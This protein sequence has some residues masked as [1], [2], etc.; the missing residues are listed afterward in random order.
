MKRIVLRVLFVFSLGLM[1]VPTLVFA[2]TNE[3]LNQPNIMKW[4]LGI[5]GTGLLGSIGYILKFRNAIKEI[6]EFAIEL[7][8]YISKQAESADLKVVK[9]EGHEAFDSIADIIEKVGMKKQAETL[10]NLL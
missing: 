2:G 10:R 4:V 8:K 9:T 6:S 5:T 1:L 7:K 3:V